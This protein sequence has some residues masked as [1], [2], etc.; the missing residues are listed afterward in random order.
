MLCGTNDMLSS[1][2]YNEQTV[3]SKPPVG[4]TITIEWLI[5]LSKEDLS[6]RSGTKLRHWTLENNSAKLKYANT[7]EPSARAPLGTPPARGRPGRTRTRSPLRSSSLG[8]GPIDA[9][10]DVVRAAAAVF[11]AAAAA[12]FFVAAVVVGAVVVGVVVVVVSLS[13]AWRRRPCSSV[14]S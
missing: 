1:E 7:Q 10:H 14:A 3:S 4:D 12:V 13:R 11:A 5:A 8:G 2:L 9:F 6:E